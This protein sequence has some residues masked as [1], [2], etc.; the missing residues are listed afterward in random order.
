MSVSIRLSKYGTK[1]PVHIPDFIE[2]L[3]AYL[4]PCSFVTIT[5]NRCPY[6]KE[7]CEEYM[8]ISLLANNHYCNICVNEIMREIYNKRI[9]GFS[10]K[11]YLLKE[12]FPSDIL[13]NI[14]R[15]FR[16]KMLSIQIRE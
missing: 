15:Y 5:L 7:I 13:Y 9:L 6:C 8:R 12:I 4:A 3:Y 16:P 10:Q 1:N 14:A 2:N 11:A